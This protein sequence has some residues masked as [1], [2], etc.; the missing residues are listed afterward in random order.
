MRREWLLRGRCSSANIV[1]NSA[2]PVK[3]TAVERA[4]NLNIILLFFLLLA[5][6][7]GSTVGS[8]IRT[9]R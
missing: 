9:V 6:S 3:R 8:S 5:L 1:E 7:A 2:A 4:V